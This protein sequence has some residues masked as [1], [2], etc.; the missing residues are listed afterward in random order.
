MLQ[1]VEAAGVPRDELRTVLDFGCGAGR[2][3]RHFPRQEG[4]E[5]WGVDISAEHVAWCREHL[6]AM[7]FATVTTAPH[8][9]FADDYFDFVFCSSVFTHITD[10]ADAWL[11]ELRRVVRRGGH[12]YLTVCDHHSLDLL[13]GPW[14]SD[15]GNMGLMMDALSDLD[16]EPAVRSRAFTFLSFGRD[17]NSFVFYDIERLTARW[18]RLFDVKVVRPEAHDFQTAVLLEV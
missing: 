1:T 8:L 13:R 6:T 2:M 5:I 17:P 11:L 10:L 4:S 14:R 16:H 12:V 3:L 9:P 7:N 15:G 18:S